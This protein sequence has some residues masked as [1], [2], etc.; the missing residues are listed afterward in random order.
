MARK[1][2]F[3]NIKLRIIAILI[4]TICSLIV[5]N[6]N[7]KS[8]TIPTRYLVSLQPE[9]ET[10]FQNR[11]ISAYDFGGQI[12]DC[13]NNFDIPAKGCQLLEKQAREFIYKHW[14]DKKRAYIILEN[15]CDVCRESYVFIEPDKNGNWHIVWRAEFSDFERGFSFNISN[16]E[17]TSVVYKIAT[18][19]ND[20][21]EIGTKLLSFLDKNGK[22]RHLF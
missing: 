1:F 3:K 6:W 20:W 16:E 11:D 21:Y 4:F 17:M 13:F 7:S 9:P 10:I 12:V 18:A 14:Q 2:V 8:K 15:N 5:W 19:E 22:E